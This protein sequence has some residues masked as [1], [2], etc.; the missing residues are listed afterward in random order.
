MIQI[1]SRAVAM[2]NSL[3]PTYNSGPEY[4]LKYIQIDGGEWRCYIYNMSKRYTIIVV[5]ILKYTR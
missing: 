2:L 1:L 5:E 3:V 4:S